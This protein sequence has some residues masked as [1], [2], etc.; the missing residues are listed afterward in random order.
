MNPAHDWALYALGL[1]VG[2]IVGLIAPTV[3]AAVHRWEEWL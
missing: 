1:C 3:W 2:C